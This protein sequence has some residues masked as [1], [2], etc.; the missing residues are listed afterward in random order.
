MISKF[1]I[2]RPKDFFVAISIFFLFFF[3]SF[4]LS[5]NFVQF[6]FHEI[7]IDVLSLIHP[8]FYSPLLESIFFSKNH[9]F[10]F[11]FIDRG[12]YFYF[13]ISISSRISAD[14]L[15]NIIIS[16]R[17]RCTLFKFFDHRHINW[18]K[19]CDVQIRKD[20][21][22]FFFFWHYIQSFFHFGI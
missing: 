7:F 19:F 11:S 3:Y 22:D 18:A 13:P 12:I 9:T 4:Q 17:S 20:R 2:V 15:T 10:N 16:F 1:S 21:H 6:I 14:K 5:Y 8:C